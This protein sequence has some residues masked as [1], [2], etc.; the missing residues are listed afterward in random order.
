MNMVLVQQIVYVIGIQ[1]IHLL[2]RI[3]NKRNVIMG[4]RGRSIDIIQSV[5]QVIMQRMP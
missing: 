2:L 1:A 3:C 4:R 5:A